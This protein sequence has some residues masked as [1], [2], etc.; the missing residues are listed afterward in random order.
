MRN[1]SPAHSPA[2]SP[3]A[4]PWIS[5]MTSL[6]SLG[7]RS[8]IATRISSSSS[9]RRSRERVSSSRSSGSSPSSASSSSAPAASSVA[10]RHSSASFAAGSSRLYSRPTSAKRLRSPMT[11]GSVIARESSAKRDSIWLTRDSITAPARVPPG[12]RDRGSEA[13]RVRQPAQEALR[14]G[15]PRRTEQLGGR[16]TLEDRAVV[17][18]AHLVGDVARE[19]HLVGGDEHRHAL[20]LELAYELEHLA[21]KLRVERARDLVEQQR[22]R[23]G[24]ERADDRDALLLAARQPVGA[25]VLAP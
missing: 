21:D 15:P 22:A 9:P 8:T 19:A 16:A 24:R 11:S 17:E 2:S 25:L 7:S 10:R 20:G 5:T 3:P 23:A 6:S 1:R 13:A 4:P 14:L 18:E 12:R